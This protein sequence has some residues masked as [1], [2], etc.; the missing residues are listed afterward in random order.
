LGDSLERKILI[1]GGVELG[2]KATSRERRLD[3]EAK[4]TIVDR[5]KVFS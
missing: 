4:I 2:P 5:S 1:I 3:P